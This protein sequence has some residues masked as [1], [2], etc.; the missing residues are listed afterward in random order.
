MAEEE[1]EK[2]EKKEEVVTAEQYKQLQAEFT[3]TKQEISQL[4]E[5]NEALAAYLKQ[6]PSQQA[7]EEDFGYVDKQSFKKEIES[8]RQMLVSTQRLGEFRSKYPDMRPYE[9]LVSV[10]I[11]KTD[12]KQSVDARV[13]KAV[14]LTRAFL[15][16]ERNKGKEFSEKEKAEKAKAEAETAG[17]DTTET[18]EESTE[19]KEET[20]E[21]YIAWRKQRSLKA[22]GII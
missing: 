7:E 8:L 10:Y 18:V 16:S 19:P 15:E 11:N 6:Q 22:Q 1:K 12:A 21:D 4:K 20:P 5:Y 17:L 3:K 2:V 13:D 14:E 9:D